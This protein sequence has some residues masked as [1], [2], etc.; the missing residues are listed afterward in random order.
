MSLFLRIAWR[1]L[2]RHR[3]RTVIVTLA[4]G[5]TLG[6][7]MM[8]DGLVAGFDQ[9][10]YGNA[11]RILGGNI[12]VHA[13]GYQDKAD[14]LPLLPLENDQ[15]VIDAAANQPQ[16][17][18]ASRRISTG[19]LATSREGAFSVSIIG[20][21]P[22][23]E[24]AISLPA[25]HIVSGR[26]LASTD[27]E[28]VLIGRGLAEEMGVGVNSRITLVG[29]ATHDKMRQRSMT[30]VGI[31]D[32][33]MPEIEKRSVY[34]ALGE[35]QALY[36]LE[37]QVSEVAI[38]LKD[39]GKEEPVITA[40]R[41]GLPG[42]EIESWRTNFPELGQ[43]LQTKGGVMNIF[44]VIILLI[45]GIG[46]LNLLLMAVFERTREIGLLGALGVKPAQISLLFLLEGALMGLVGV[47]FGVVLGLVFNLLLG[48]V[49]LDYTAFSG[50]AEYMAL[51]DGRVYPTLGVDK[52]YQRIPT[53]LII[54]VLAAFVPAREAA[55]H[56]PAQ[57][58]H[59]V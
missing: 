40:L 54:S 17:L 48:Q 5:L 7:M 30:V 37:E 46:I 28:M 9:A 18:V 52:L 56:E 13:L 20:V 31:F 57:A 21:E 39:L 42:Y 33:D 41:A 26:Y 53:A 32:V 22:E 44:S 8:Y 51:I 23:K 25:Q 58:L 10:I 34:I 55:Q 15:A 49:G 2:W 45:S 14:Q 47:A 38:F 19:G 24:Q 43:A 35:A 36:G 29:Q 27:Q 11:V 3:R 59:T 4:I 1:N 16:V 50:A 6:M 12:Q